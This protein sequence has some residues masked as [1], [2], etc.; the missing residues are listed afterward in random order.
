[1]VESWT[2]SKPQPMVEFIIPNCTWGGPTG[3]WDAKN[4]IFSCKLADSVKINRIHWITQFTINL[5][6]VTLGGRNIYKRS[7]KY[8]LYGIENTTMIYRF[9]SKTMGFLSSCSP[10]LRR[11]RASQ[12]TITKLH[13]EFFA[14]SKD[15]WEP[16]NHSLRM[17]IEI[18]W[19]YHWNHT[20]I[21]KWICDDKKTDRNSGGYEFGAFL[22]HGLDPQVTITWST[23]MTWGTM[24]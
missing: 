18:Q 21:K 19:D 4:G 7:I 9:T 14:R 15:Q 23:W 16:T 12:C 11:W 20:E 6:H 8:A 3:W 5:Y 2:E 22:N 10:R 13:L 1:M 17:G 24:T